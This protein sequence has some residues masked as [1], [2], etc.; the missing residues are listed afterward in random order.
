MF[1]ITAPVTTPK[2][3]LNNPLVKCSDPNICSTTLSFACP[4]TCGLCGLYIHVTV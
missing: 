2:P 3:C 1:Y 4:A